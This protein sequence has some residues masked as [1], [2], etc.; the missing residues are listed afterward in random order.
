MGSAAVLQCSPVGVVS[1]E[2][3]HHIACT[4]LEEQRQRQRRRRCGQ[5]EPEREAITGRRRNRPV[6]G[7]HRE[8]DEQR[9]QLAK[10]HGGCWPKRAPPSIFRFG[11]HAL[12]SACS[13][14]NRTAGWARDTCRSRARGGNATPL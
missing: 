4:E 3:T 1:V 7:E 9:R 6:G 12:V 5:L 11:G 14:P 8:R 13:E 2:V 10:L